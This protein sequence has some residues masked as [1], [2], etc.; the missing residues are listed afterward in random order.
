MTTADGALPDDWALPAVTAT[1]AAWFCSATVA[2]QQCAACGALQH[3]PEEIC[4][5]CAATTFTTRTMAPRGTVHSYTVV[6]HAVHP[7]LE[8]AVPYAVVLV[9]LHDAPAVRVVGN[10]LGVP[11]GEISIGM[12][13]VATWQERTADDGTV[14]QLP[15]WER[16]PGAG[17]TDEEDER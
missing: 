6:H 4:H 9:S 11:V 2:V 15:Q 5:H 7:A 1:N 12:P 13:V 8:A 10:L 16:P 3:P 17:G 14:V